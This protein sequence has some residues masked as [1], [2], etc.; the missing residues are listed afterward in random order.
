ML[1][2]KMCLFF[3]PPQPQIKWLI[4]KEL[5]WWIIPDGLLMFICISCKWLRIITLERIQKQEKLHSR[6]YLIYVVTSFPAFSLNE[7]K[8]TLVAS[9]CL[10]LKN[11]AVLSFSGWVISLAFEMVKIPSGII[12]FAFQWSVK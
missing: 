1:S 10:C 3:S 8:A 9:H 12:S 5:W 6:N 2:W 7:S 4:K 11:F